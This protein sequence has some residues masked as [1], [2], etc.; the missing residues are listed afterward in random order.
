MSKR[1]QAKASEMASADS[2]QDL[3]SLDQFFM[4]FAL[5]EARRAKD[6]GEVPIGAVVVIDKQ[7]VGS[8]HNQPIGL[9]DP[10]AHAEIL[11]MR[12]AAERIANYRLTEATLYVTIEPCAMCAGA[13]VNARIKRLVY[14]ATEIRAGAV[15]SVFQICTNSSLN[16]QVEVTSGIRADECRELMQAFFKLRRKTKVENS[17]EPLPE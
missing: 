7:I 14:G 13:M 15:D 2:L 17:T 5:A 1:Q 10:T 16:H 8:G 9:N 3:N 6:A 12:R 11:A 4:G